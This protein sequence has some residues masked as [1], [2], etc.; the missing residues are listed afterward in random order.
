MVERCRKWH[1]NRLIEMKTVNLQ[2]GSNETRKV[3]TKRVDVM[4]V[5]RTQNNSAKT[6]TPINA[7][8]LNFEN[9]HTINSNNEK[10]THSLAE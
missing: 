2:F 5:K 3:L 1:E 6:K 4:P 9:I 8:V 10:N 7:V